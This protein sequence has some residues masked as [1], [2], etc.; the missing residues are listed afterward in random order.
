MELTGW[1]SERRG[2]SSPSRL[3]WPCALGAAQFALIGRFELTFDE[4]YYTLWS[5]DLA[6]GYFDH[7]PMIAAWIRA[8]TTLFGPH[9]PGV[10]ALDLVAFATI[11]A[12]VGLTGARLFSSAR[13]G[14]LA[15]AVWLTTP[16]I[17][18]GFLA[19]PDVPLTFF[20][21]VALLGLVEVWRGRE[22]AWALVGVALGLAALAKFTAIFLGCGVALAL[23]ATPSL[24]RCLRTFAPYA[25][26]A[27]ALAI[28]APFV[29]W[30]A[31]HDWQTFAKQF[32]RVPAHE[33]APGHLL[34]FAAGQLAVGNPLW[35]V[36][37][38][39]GLAPALVRRADEET[40]ARRLPAL[41]IAPAVLYFCIH[42]LHD[43]VEANWTAPLYPAIAILAGEAAAR[44]PQWAKR[45]AA[46][47]GL[48]GATA[49]TL[50]FAHVVSLWPPLGA[51]DPLARFGGWREVARSVD[52][53]A[54]A[55]NAAFILAQ[56][57][58]ATSLLTYYG[59]G[60]TPVMEL[61]EHARWIFQPPPEMKL[62][63]ASGLALGEPDFDY[64]K[65]LAQQF[66]RVEFIR[67]VERK[68]G[69]ADVGDYELYRVADPIPPVFVTP[70]AARRPT[71][72]RGRP[73]YGRRPR[74]WLR[75]RRAD[76]APRCS[77]PL[78]RRAARRRR[79]FGRDGEKL[80]RS[81]GDAIRGNA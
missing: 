24:R 18:G 6:W 14:V 75:S 74:G 4:A 44:G 79:A 26:A 50:I 29:L 22:A 38:A 12:L 23:V 32:S 76:C 11:P 53:E 31:Q 9:E 34:E 77:Q 61:R 27:L 15:A 70:Y 2:G 64:G 73:I 19:T 46:V 13:A 51:A 3:P 25:A 5:R 55:E 45:A 57:Y 66:R 69:D 65:D 1:R 42:A 17:A 63:A 28:F 71:G 33:F 49:I 8:S 72:R 56:T 59:D 21:I 7:P 43:R 48:I 62:F 39:V 37:A 67:R 10:R 47:A 30:N 40:E 80:A 16:L 58:G 81:A 20:A 78:L 52:A 54:H 36:V 60:A 41:Y 68:L 35:L